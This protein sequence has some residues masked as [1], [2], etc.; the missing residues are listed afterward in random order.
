MMFYT[1]KIDRFYRVHRLDVSF[2]LAV[3]FTLKRTSLAVVFEKDCI[4]VKL[5]FVF[6]DCTD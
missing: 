5:L 1:N 6:T 2:N 4:Y 3:F